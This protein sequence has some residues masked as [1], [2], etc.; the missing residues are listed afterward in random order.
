MIIDTSD[1]NT[2]AQKKNQR[3]EYLNI[4]DANS[5]ENHNS[6]KS[7]KKKK[8]KQ[9]KK[10]SNNDQENPQDCLMEDNFV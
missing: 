2:Q 8:K 3:D 5:S 10:G 7:K 1:Q 6:F 9:K 4:F